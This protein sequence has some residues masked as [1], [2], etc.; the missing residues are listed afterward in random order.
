MN[1][2]EW[3]TELQHRINASKGNYREFI[4]LLV[5]DAEEIIALL[6]EYEEQKRKWLQSM[7]PQIL[8]LNDAMNADVCWLENKKTGSLIPVG[9]FYESKWTVSAYPPGK[10]GINYDVAKYG[11]TYRCWSCCPDEE[12]RK[13]TEWNVKLKN[14]R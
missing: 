8:S 2:Q 4:D 6:K 12:L 1:R 7:K 13:N 10:C 9:V 5:E 11:K 3:I 14:E